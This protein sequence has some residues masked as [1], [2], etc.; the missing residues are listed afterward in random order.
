MV[1]AH[2]KFPKNIAV[3]DSDAA[4]AKMTEQALLALGASRVQIFTTGDEGLAA[5]TTKT[6]D[7][8]VID[9]KLKGMISGLAVLARIRRR[10]DCI[11][12][13]VAFTAGQISHSELLV[14][15]EF[16]C[17]VSM[18]KPIRQ[19]H[20][21]EMLLKTASEREW[22]L[23]NETKIGAAFNVS[24]FDP[25][26][27][28][29]IIHELI[30]SSPRRTPISLL[31]AEHY[32]EQKLYKEAAELYDR[33]L[34][35]V[36]ESLP[37]LS[38]KARLFSLQGKHK[39]AMAVLQK[40]QSIAPKSIERLLLMGDIEISL[41]NPKAA[42]QHFHKV[43]DL[44]TT[45]SKAKIGKA[46]ASRLPN[47]ISQKIF[48]ANAEPS[49]AKILN[50]LGV[51]LA[52]SKKYEKAIQYYL[53]SFSFLANETLRSK[54]SFNMGLGF[55]RWEKLPQAKYW[56]EQA[57]TLARGKFPKAHRQ[58]IGLE[59]VIALA[60]LMT[61]EGEKLL[62]LPKPAG[63]L[64]Q[65]PLDTTALAV[66]PMSNDDIFEEETMNV[67]SSQKAALFDDMI[68]EIDRNLSDSD[69]FLDP[70]A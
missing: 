51:Q 1:D 55:K 2:T 21:Q 50:N 17:T 14:L 27:S 69:L 63:P 61:D 43:L 25:Q 13:P 19:P 36:P 44:D 60:G 70:A 30:K 52:V 35:E 16:P 11:Y 31:A 41:K 42:I 39:N 20:L 54:V 3:L 12:M 26:K 37:A 15:Q 57:L 5:L 9:W 49:I 8:A 28:A 46:V 23:T 40:A 33:I 64:H 32:V 29:Q 45:N 18:L 38:A 6:F 59:E 62:K 66:G 7:A 10:P 22:Y 65:L 34:S 68:T 67:G 47:L 48:E 53:L 24:Q 58:L 4:T 56:L